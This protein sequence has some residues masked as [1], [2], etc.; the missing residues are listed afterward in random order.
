[1]PKAKLANTRLNTGGPPASAPRD[2]CRLP[3]EAIRAYQPRAASTNL[4]LRCWG[5]HVRFWWV[6]HNQTW[7]EEIA[8]G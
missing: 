3:P 5:R 1:M 7:Q 6:N 2:I 8:G 4:A